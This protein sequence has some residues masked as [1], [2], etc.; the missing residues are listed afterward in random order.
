MQQELGDHHPQTQNSLLATK[1]FNVQVLLD[2]DTQTLYGILQALAQ[3][4]NLPYPDTKTDLM[5]LERIATNSQLLQSL[6]QA[7]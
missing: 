3:H 4:A 7:L 1:M 5:L 6:R 2:C